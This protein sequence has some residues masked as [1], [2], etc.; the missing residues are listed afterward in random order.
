MKEQD[1]VGDGDW[2]KKKKKK[3]IAKGTKREGGRTRFIIFTLAPLSRRN[4][5]VSR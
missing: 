1:S 2:G 3:K 5:V 4:L